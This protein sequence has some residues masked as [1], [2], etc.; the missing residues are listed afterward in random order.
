[1]TSAF[2]Q[3]PTLAFIKQQKP[4][5]VLSSISHLQTL[6]DKAGVSSAAE[7]ILH[8]NISEEMQLSVYVEK[9]L[10]DLALAMARVYKGKLYLP[11]NPRHAFDQEH[12]VSEVQNSLDRLNKGGVDLNRIGYLFPATWEG[13]LA[14]ESVQKRGFTSAIEHV[15]SLLQ[16]AQA[17]ERGI[18]LI[19]TSLEN[20]RSSD[21][22]LRLPLA[23]GTYLQASR[24]ETEL[25]VK[26]VSTPEE[27]K[28]FLPYMSVAIKENLYSE[29]TA[30]NLPTP[31]PLNLQKPEPLPLLESTFRFLLNEDPRATALL[32][33][34][35]RDAAAALR[36]IESTFPLR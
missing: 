34:G 22:G 30:I 16:A 4:E 15:Y 24:Y 31:L 21:K 13:I 28:L 9:L 26:D 12:L 8:Q 6:I 29:R 1:M 36:K 10:S 17:G 32:E 20:L 7:H 33:Q 2:V 3:F 35:I 25:L 19:V 23:L 14:A 18:G 5:S 11:T 27:F